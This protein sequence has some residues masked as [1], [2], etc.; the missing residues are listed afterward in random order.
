MRPGGS[1]LTEAMSGWASKQIG[2]ARGGLK[3]NRDR[4]GTAILLP[5]F[6]TFSYAA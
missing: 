2:S 5:V 4:L 6:A 1:P 3:L